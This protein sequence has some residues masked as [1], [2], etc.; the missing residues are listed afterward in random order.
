MHFKRALPI[1][2]LLLSSLNAH[3]TLTSYNREGVD[4]VYSSVSDVTWTK[5]ANLFKTLYDA[6]NGLISKIAAVTPSFNDATLGLQT[7]GESQFN[8][9]NGRVN[10][11]GALAFVNYLNH[12]QYAGSDQWR[13]PAVAKAEVSYN[14]SAVNGTAAGGELPE[15]F[16]QELGGTAFHA[17][18]DSVSFGQVRTDYFWS[19]IEYASSPR[20]AWNFDTYT[21]GQYYGNKY[22]QFS[23][24]VVSPGLVAAVPEAD[25]SAMLLA[26][27]GM[28]AVVLR[29]RAE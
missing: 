11:W 20:L 5:D 21:G 1:I 26:G 19:G 17:M 8:I 7:I 6:D 29:R 28:M 15:L 24:W 9:S 14:P 4:L 10:W 16:Y 3:A 18:P 13:L 2:A 12:I 27:L 23:A 25:N 22:L